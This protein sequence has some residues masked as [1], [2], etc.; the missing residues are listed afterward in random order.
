MTLPVFKYH[1]DPV[2][3]G[4]VV[5]SGETC[6]CCGKARGFI[7]EGAVYGE[8]EIGGALCPWC[9][10]DGSAAAK[11]GAAFSDENGLLDADLR[12]EIVEEITQRTP[13]FIAWSQDDWLICCDD[14]CAYLGDA[15]KGE[16][17]TLSGDKL[18]SVLEFLEWTPSQW[19][20]FL[21]RYE[22]AGDHAMHKF[23]CRHCGAA[24]YMSDPS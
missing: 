15:E 1:P 12:K 8:K 24:H 20:D 2:A 18:E 21:A 11:F 3:T 4:A 5:E 22:P 10:A 16:L 6:A 7:Y 17:Q 9:I 23:L 19:A 13:G 14:A